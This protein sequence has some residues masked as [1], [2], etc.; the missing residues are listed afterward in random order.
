MSEQGTL[1]QQI[2]AG[3]NR[4][5]QVMAASG[6]VPLPPELLVP[7][8]VALTE[9]PDGEI[10]GLARDGLGA[11]E[12]RIAIDYLESQATERELRWFAENVR[13]P[14]IMDAIL[15]R[16]DVPRPLLMALAPKLWPEAQETLLLR[17]DAVIEEPRILVAL[18]SNPEL[19]SYAKRRIWE[20]R[21]HLLPRDKVP[22]KKPEEVLA[23][24]DAWSEAEVLEAIE[25]ARG[26]PI[27]GEKVDDLH[28]LN[29]GQIRS[30]PVPVRIRM[31]RGADRL[32]RSVLAR[33]ANA[34]VATTVLTGRISDKEIELFAN[35]R[36]VH[37][38]VLVM[39]AKR[40]EWVRRYAVAK[41]LAKN[42]R[43]HIAT[44]IRLLSRLTLNDMRLLSRDRNVPQAVR[45]A[46]QRIYLAKR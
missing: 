46:A 30:L 15:R 27:E 29:D 36:S 3:D 23:E 6:L 21:E 31:A 22:P 4:Q 25:E 20:Y 5:L 45:S 17:Q 37:Q 8:Q 16:S 13:Q 33:D 42:P 19:S 34:Q 39:I 14:Q 10:A 2:L 32:L 18:E 41:A 11:L 28:G 7:V 40:R 43:T 35:S 9:S 12:P 38:D 24:A 44:A 1:L 26:R